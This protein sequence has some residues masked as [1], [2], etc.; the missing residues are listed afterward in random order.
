M[1]NLQRQN[2][3]QQ[4]GSSL[5]LLKQKGTERES[6]QAS[7]DRGFQIQNNNFKEHK[8]LNSS[9]QVHAGLAFPSALLIE[10]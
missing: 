8:R 10:S 4:Q 5:Y 1:G 6:I 9:P 7:T 3:A 2:K